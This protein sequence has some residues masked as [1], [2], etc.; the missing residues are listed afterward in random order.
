[1]SDPR[2]ALLVA[3]GLPVVVR[4]AL[5]DVQLPPAARLMMWHLQGHLDLVEWTPVKLVGIAH[6]TRTRESTCSRMLSLLVERG[7]LL[8][9]PDQRKGRAYRFPWSR[10]SMARAA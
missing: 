10:R 1:M 6:E 7:Y 8:T 5:D 2:C 4:Q 3:H 9:R